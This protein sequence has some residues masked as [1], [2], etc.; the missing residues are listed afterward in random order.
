MYLHTMYHLIVNKNMK[1]FN[2]IDKSIIDFW[3]AH[4][5]TENDMYCRKCGL[6]MIDI[7]ELNDVEVKIN[8]HND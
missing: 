3:N 2:D 1:T 5:I 4:G 7:D 6:L 8:A